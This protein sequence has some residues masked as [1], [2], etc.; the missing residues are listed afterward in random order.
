MLISRPQSWFDIKTEVALCP[1]STRESLHQ[2]IVSISR[3]DASLR[4]DFA[5]IKPRARRRVTPASFPPAATAAAPPPRRIRLLDTSHLRCS[6]IINSISLTFPRA[7]GL[8]RRFPP[9][10]RPTFA[11]RANHL[12]MVLIN[13]IE[14]SS[15]FR[16]E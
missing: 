16:V 3:Q 1:R 15:V 2:S 8:C 13:V 7:P 10:P 12:L 4:L 5:S 6:E 9:L 14:S 11:I